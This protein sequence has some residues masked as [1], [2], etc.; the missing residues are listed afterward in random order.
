M[1]TV[2]IIM[3]LGMLIGYLLRSKTH[4]FKKV[5]RWVSLTIYLLL[6]LLGVSVGKNDIVVKNIHHIGIQALIITLA[7]IAGS[8]IL[9]GVVYFFFFRKRTEP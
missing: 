2:V 5:D 7:A 1:L 4:I 9:C 8:V 6:F 3:T